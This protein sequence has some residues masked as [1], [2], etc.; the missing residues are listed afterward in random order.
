LNAEKTTGSVRLKRELM[1]QRKRV[2]S[3]EQVTGSVKQKG[4]LIRRSN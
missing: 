2:S 3:V 1:R 4:E